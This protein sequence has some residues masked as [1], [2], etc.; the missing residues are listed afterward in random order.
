MSPMTPRAPGMFFAERYEL[1]REIGGAGEVWEVQDTNSG[2]RVAL[3][4]L[5]I[6]L[7][8]SRSTPEYFRREGEELSALEHPNVARTFEAGVADGQAYLIAELVEGVSL[9]EL[10]AGRKDRHFLLSE[11]VELCEQ[12]AAAVE[13]AHSRGILHLDLTP[14]K[15]MV[16]KHGERHRLK[17]IDFGLA[18]MFSEQSSES[19]PGPLGAREHLAP[20]QMKGEAVGPSADVFALGMIFFELLT[21]HRPVLQNG[22]PPNTGLG[23]RADVIVKKVLA[24]DPAARYLSAGTFAIAVRALEHPEEPRRPSPIPWL[25]LV[26][27]VIVILVAIAQIFGPS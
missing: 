27:L 2:Q 20:E 7:E 24:P 13:H 3:K 15:V 12:L 4:I 10:I 25:G 11:V 1:V 5:K 6:S 23:V 21:L 14:S 26:V 16:V 17:V 22:R 18:K 9:E 19:A 8:A